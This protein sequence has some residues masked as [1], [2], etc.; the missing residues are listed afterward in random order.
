MLLLKAGRQ[1]DDKA[2]TQRDELSENES[3]FD[4]PNL[5]QGLHNDGSQQRRRS[6]F[7]GP[8]YFSK[9]FH[10]QN[11]KHCCTI[12]IFLKLN[13]KSEWELRFHACISFSSPGGCW[14]PHIVKD[15]I[16]VSS[17]SILLLFPPNQA[18]ADRSRWI[19]CVLVSPLF[20]SVQAPADFPSLSFM[21]NSISC[22]SFQAPLSTETSR[23]PRIIKSFITYRVLESIFLPRK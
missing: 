15:M 13:R 12:S 23:H 22:S 21:S 14:R 6:C 2:H 11:T 3:Q 7:C 17:N 16:S 18:V 8:I 19:Y 10:L 9:G 5:I 1:T 20:L 4:L